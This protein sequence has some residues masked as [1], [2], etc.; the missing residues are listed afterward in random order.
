[1]SHYRRAKRHEKWDH[2]A[3]DIMEGVQAE[4]AQEAAAQAF[5]TSTED[6]AEEKKKLEDQKEFFNVKYLIDEK[7]LIVVVICTAIFVYELI[8]CVSF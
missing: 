7:D 4:A 2:R 5:C 6:F 1:M 8:V 3:V